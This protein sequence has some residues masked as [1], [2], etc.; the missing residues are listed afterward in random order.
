MNKNRYKNR[1]IDKRHEQIMNRLDDIRDQVEETNGRVSDLENWR[2]R[3]IG[4]IAV[5]TTFLV[6]LMLSAVESGIF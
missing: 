4:A 3:I 5:I 2:N 1:E 6:P